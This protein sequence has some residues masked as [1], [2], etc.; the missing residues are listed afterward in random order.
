[1]TAEK[2]KLEDVLITDQL[3]RRQG[4]RI[5]PSKQNDAFLTLAHEMSYGPGAI[6][7][8]LCHL[9]I[10]LCGAGTGGVSVLHSDEEAEYFSWDAMVGK[11]AHYE[12]GTAP[13]DHSPCGVCLER[14]AP[15]LFSFPEKYF[16]ELKATV[17]IV[18][19]LV[20]PL[21]G[22]MSEAIG[23][24]WILSHDE[25]RRFNVEHLRIMTELGA[26]TSRALR[27]QTS[28]DHHVR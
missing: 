19:G 25:R 11:L 26:Y 4:Q 27:L 16:T 3:Y 13:R 18:E 14:N 2:V 20:I 23:A 12:G 24:I 8:T 17:P 28:L 21:Y 22:E 15:Q 6:L 9:A 7:H 5:D 10:D 1:M